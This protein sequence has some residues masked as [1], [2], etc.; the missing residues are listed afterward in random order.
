[1]FRFAVT[2]TTADGSA[3]KPAKAKPNREIAR[4]RRA[5]P[6]DRASFSDDMQASD[7]DCDEFVEDDDVE[8][9]KG[10]VA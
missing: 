1:M 5:R 9:D 2:S 6:S 10:N 3:Q 7:L 4:R 8:T